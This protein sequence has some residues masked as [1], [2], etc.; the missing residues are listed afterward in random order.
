MPTTTE[1]AGIAWTG[2]GKTYQLRLLQQTA[3]LAFSSPL[4]VVSEV[5]RM[6]GSSGLSPLAPILPTQIEFLIQDDSAT[7]ETKFKT[8]QSRA[9]IV[10]MTEDGLVIFFGYLK[11]EFQE[12]LVWHTT[13]T[14]RMVAA[15]GIADLAGF[16]YD[17]AGAQTIREQVYNI[18]NKTGLDLPLNISFEWAEDGADAATE[19]PDKLRY[20]MENLLE[21]GGTYLDALKELC[22]FY[23]AQFYQRHGEWHFV[24]RSL[25]SS[26]TMT[27]YKVTSTGAA[28]TADTF[29][30][31]QTLTSADLHRDA[32]IVTEWQQASRVVTRTKYIKTLLRNPDFADGQTY[33]D[34]TSEAH[35]LGRKL[36]SNADFLEQEVGATF[37]IADATFDKVSF[38]LESRVAVDSLGTGTGDVELAEVTVTSKLG[39]TNWMDNAGN[40]QSTSTRITE[41]VDL[42]ANAGTEVDVSPAIASAQVPFEPCVVVVKLVHNEDPGVGSPYINYTIHKAVSAKH[43]TPDEADDIIRPESVTS[44]VETTEPGDSDEREFLIGDASGDHMAPGVLEYFDGSDWPKAEDFDGSGQRVHALR[45]TDRANQIAAK[46]PGY[47]FAHTFGDRIEISDVFSYDSGSGAETFIPIMVETIFPR[48]GAPTSRSVAYRLNTESA[49]PPPGLELPTP[50]KIYE[51]DLNLAKNIAQ[52]G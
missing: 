33:W 6:A 14:L 16:T 46:L 34:G 29:N 5:Q 2:G 42:G 37:Q 24:Q 23:N 15:D 4:K 48:Q 26:S 35:S 41:S 20:R 9:F 21:R 47:E 28:D 13:P 39:V 52:Y 43:L 45:T 36:D 3:L 40:W 27:R 17:Q 12:R 1:V 18:A 19:P 8:G 44:T 38:R 49:A 7:L 31:V 22:L 51:Y 11:P 10:E 30:Y 32:T 50:A 25:R